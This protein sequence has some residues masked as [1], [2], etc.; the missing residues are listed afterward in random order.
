MTAINVH[1]AKTRLS[2]LLKLIEKGE[3]VII[4]RHGEPVAEITKPAKTPRGFNRLTPHRKLSQIKF[5]YD[6]T[7]P[8]QP[9]EWPEELR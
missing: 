2:A 4:C 7:E 9:G 6:P 8:L 5:D 3:T 1:E